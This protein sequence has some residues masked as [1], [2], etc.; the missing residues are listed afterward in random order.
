MK[1]V[2]AIDLAMAQ[3][4]IGHDSYLDATE[5][6]NNPNGQKVFHWLARQEQIHF[7]A[8]KRLR[9]ALVRDAPEEAEHSLTSPKPPRWPIPRE[10]TEST[11]AQ[12]ALQMAIEYEKASVSFYRTTE[13]FIPDE[14]AK[15]MF[16]ELVREEQKHLQLVEIQLD[17]LIRGESF[18]DLN[19]PDVAKLL[20]VD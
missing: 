13:Q 12:E 10:V 2:D 16:S 17:A 1:Q 14:G 5:T 20:H 3:E 4:K 9:D 7:N 8:L 19:S 6:T 15:T 11:T 18:I